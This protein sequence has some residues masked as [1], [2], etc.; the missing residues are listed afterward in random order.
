MS[1]GFV[2]SPHAV[3]TRTLWARQTVA[4]TIAGTELRK[5]R[6]DHGRQ[7]QCE[8]GWTPQNTSELVHVV[9]ADLG[10]DLDAP[11]THTDPRRTGPTAGH[12]P[13]KLSN[14]SGNS[15]RHPHGCH[16]ASGL[17]APPGSTPGFA[18]ETATSHR[19]NTHEA[20]LVELRTCTPTDPVRIRACDPN[21]SRTRLSPPTCSV[22]P[23][24][25]HTQFQVRILGSPLRGSRQNG[26]ATGL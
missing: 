19:T 21:R 15:P 23:R 5:H 3:P 11:G 17:H 6:L 20:H 13:E 25:A 18:I 16:T 1:W 9:H 26:K 24:L 2:S 12:Q 10:L 4:N 7:L 14:N 22:P 8:R